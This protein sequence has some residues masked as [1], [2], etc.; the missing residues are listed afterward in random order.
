MKL[1][2]RKLIWLLFIPSVLLWAQEQVRMDLQVT[3]FMKLLKYD[4]N[5]T[6]RGA[7]GLKLGVL[8]NPDDPRSVKTYKEFEK[9]FNMLDNKTI[10]GMT[11]ILVPVK[12]AKSLAAAIKNFGINLLYIC[13]GFDSQLSDILRVC[14]ENKVLTMTG[15]P[16]YADKGVALGLAVKDGKPQIV[17]NN[18]VAKQVGSNFSAD[19][20]KLAKVIQ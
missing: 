3:L 17:I 4:R 20:L 1:I 18:S 10:K 2:W 9:K 5:I 14:N 16:P 8:Y 15:Y 7:E 13:P 19:V 6:R 11:V 12:G